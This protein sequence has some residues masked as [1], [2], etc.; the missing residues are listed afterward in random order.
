MI[1]L[2]DSQ[3][4]RYV[5]SNREAEKV[6][7]LCVKRE[8]RKRILVHNQSVLTLFRESDELKSSLNFYH[9]K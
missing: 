9:K 5:L 7:L 1:K 8:E 2:E 6:Y 3:L 4:T